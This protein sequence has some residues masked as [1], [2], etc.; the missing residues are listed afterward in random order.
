M[1]KLIVPANTVVKIRSVLKINDLKYDGGSNTVNDNSMP[2]LMA[3]SRVNC[4]LAGRHGQGV[5]TDNSVRT[6]YSE[7]DLIADSNDAAGIKNST[8]AKGKIWQSSFVEYVVHTSTAQGAWET[9]E[10]TVAAQYNS[11]ELTYGYYV[12]DTDL[13]QNGFK[14]MPI[15]VIF[16]KPD[17]TN[18][19][20]VVAT[21]TIGRKS[22]RTSFTANKKRIS[23]RI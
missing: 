20:S 13:S 3:R 6:L 14:A 15:D 2:V 4:G 9:K 18:S 7:W 5:V 12:D 19:N 1:N 11:Y 16:S 21:G 8:E 23:G 17:P 22:V 10:L